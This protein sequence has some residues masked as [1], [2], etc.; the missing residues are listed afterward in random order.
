MTRLLALAYGGLCYAV[1]LV[2]FLYSIGFV[3][4]IVVPRSVDRGIDSSL[5]E[6]I[7]VDVLLLNLF[8]VQHSV[9]AR[10]VFKRWWTRYVPRP[11]E[12][13]TYVLIASMV[14]A[15]LFWQWRTIPAVVW[16][17]DWR[18]GRLSLWAVFGLGWAT[19]LVSTFLIDH[20]DLFGLRQVYLAARGRTYTELGFSTSLLYRAVRHPLMLGFLVAFWA[21]PTMT[22]GHL[23]FAA[24]TTAYIIVAIRLEERDLTAQL[25]EP[26]RDYRTR[27]PM[28]VPRLHRRAS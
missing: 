23:L 12:R 16:D 27:V 19:V 6:A 7:I 4:D 20:W 13:S 18:P 11:I 28:L 25:G 14:L 17:V 9:M 21:I 8:A 22:A 3:G 15:L 10:P 26:Y 1:F 24:M 2:V 5:G